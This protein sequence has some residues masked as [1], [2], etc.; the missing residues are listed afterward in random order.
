MHDNPDGGWVV[1]FDTQL[2]VCTPQHRVVY[3][4]IVTRYG[5]T[6]LESQRVEAEVGRFQLQG[7]LELNSLRS[8]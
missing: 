3:S 7:H 1:V 4:Q 5:I 8:S 6:C 2:W